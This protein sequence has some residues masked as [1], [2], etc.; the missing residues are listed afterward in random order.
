M[1]VAQKDLDDRR[2][3]G[4]NPIMDVNVDTLRIRPWLQALTQ[5]GEGRVKY[6]QRCEEVGKGLPLFVMNNRHM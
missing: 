3:T 5:A 4:N 1:R 2:Y 6:P